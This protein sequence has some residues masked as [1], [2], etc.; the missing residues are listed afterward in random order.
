M[1]AAFY[2]LIHS[3]LLE[4]C[5]QT[6]EGYVTCLVKLVN[7]G[8][9]MGTKS[10]SAGKTYCSAGKKTFI[11]NYLQ[12]YSEPLILKPRIYFVGAITTKKLNLTFL[13]YHIRFYNKQDIIPNIINCP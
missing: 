1:H 3:T 7:C 4:L 10:C 13:M 6:L 8:N 12:S 11:Y 9:V 2:G 5:R